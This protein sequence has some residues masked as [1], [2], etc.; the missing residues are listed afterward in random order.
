M[1]LLRPYQLVVRSLLLAM[2]V[3]AATVIAKGLIGKCGSLP[4]TK[5]FQ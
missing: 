1:P 5:H 2:V 3:L 4:G